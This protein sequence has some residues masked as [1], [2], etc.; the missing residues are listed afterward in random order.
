[1]IQIQATVTG[2]ANRPV[3][4]FSAYDEDTKILIVGAEADYRAERRKDS[5]VITNDTTINQRD[6]LFNESQFAE[7]IRAFFALKNGVAVDGKST[8][9]IFNERAARSDPEHSIEID[10]IDTNG[11]RYRISEGVSCAQVAAL[12]TCLYASRC[13]SIANAVKMSSDLLNILSGNLVTVSAHGFEQNYG[14]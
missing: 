12:A 2:Y 4:L 3:S 11:P 9:L 6:T 10:G 5:I 14:F 13:T 1:M 7:S 8:R